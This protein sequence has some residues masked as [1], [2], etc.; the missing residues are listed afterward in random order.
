MQ[1]RNVSHDREAETG[2]SRRSTAR[3]VDAIEALEHPRMV[4]GSDTWTRVGHRDPD[5][6]RLNRNVQLHDAALRTELDCVIEQVADRRDELCAISHHAGLWEVFDRDHHRF[7]ERGGLQSGDRLLDHLHHLDGRHVGKSVEFDTGELEEVADD[8]IF[9]L[10]GRIR[11][12]GPVA[13][14]MSLTG[15]ARLEKAVAALMR[16]SGR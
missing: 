13:R 10:E 15:F 9:L 7:G 11:F 8:I 2:S 3:I 12:H 14:L 5:S 4:F 1:Q 6:C 16:P